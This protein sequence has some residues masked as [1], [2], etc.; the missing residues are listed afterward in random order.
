MRA[1]IHDRHHAPLA[2]KA[3]LGR[4]V[5]AY[6]KQLALRYLKL[7]A[8]TQIAKVE[9]S[10]SVA[11]GLRHQL[12]IFRNRLALKEMLLSVL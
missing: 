1:V 2:L 8:P 5:A 3:C 7:I 6:L 11:Q 12:V 4:Y 10:P 9:L